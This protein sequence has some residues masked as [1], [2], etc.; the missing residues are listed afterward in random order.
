L[1]STSE[2][3]KMAETYLGMGLSYQK[4]KDYSHAS[5][6]LQYASAI[7][8]S[9]AN[10]K[11]AIEAKRQYGITLMEEGMVEEAFQ[12]LSECLAE[13]N[14]HQFS[15][16]A[17]RVHND[18]AQ[19]HLRQQRSEEAKWVCLAGLTAIPKDTPEYAYLLRTLA[20]AERALGDLETAIRLA[21]EAKGVFEQ[22]H[23]P[24]EVSES[25]AQLGEFYQTAGDHVKATEHLLNMKYS[26]AEG[27][28]DR[29]I[30][31]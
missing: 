13:Y 6:Y 21:E 14:H 12:V 26:L 8:Q 31:L 10:I 22:L 11:T 30:I 5:E 23:T 3:E 9:T 18:L 19:L 2:T 29:G 1:L 17:A 25:S 24:I 4:M 7:Y 16:E 15:L 28:R 27:L 20:S